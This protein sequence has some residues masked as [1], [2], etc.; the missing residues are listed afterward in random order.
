MFDSAPALSPAPHPSPEPSDNRHHKNPGVPELSTRGFGRGRGP[1]WAPP[2][3]GKGRSVALPSS[4][5]NSIT[6]RWCCLAGMPPP[7]TP[8]WRTIPPPARSLSHP[9]LSYARRAI[10]FFDPRSCPP[11]GPRFAVPPARSQIRSQSGPGPRRRWVSLALTKVRRV[12]SSSHSTA[13]VSPSFRTSGIVSVGSPLLTM[14]NSLP[15]VNGTAGVAGLRERT[16][17]GQNSV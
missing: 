7:P 1:P 12:E 11:P 2:R 10:P 6:A 9:V 16:R 14:T 13:P 4:D 8:P 3:A 15:Q 17:V 5:D